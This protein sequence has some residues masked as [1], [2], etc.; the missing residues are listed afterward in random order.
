MELARTLPGIVSGCPRCNGQPLLVTSRGSNQSHFECPPCR[1]RLWDRP[2]EQEALA[3][4]EALPRTAP[5]AETT[6][7]NQPRAAA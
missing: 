1:V 6:E 3:D 4:W 7:P 5:A 2:S